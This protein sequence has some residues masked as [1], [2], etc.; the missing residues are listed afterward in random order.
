[1]ISRY[2]IDAIFILF[3][4]KTAL[5][6]SISTDTDDGWRIFFDNMRKISRKTVDVDFGND[7]GVIDLFLFI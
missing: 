6:S 7:T 4:D 1:M 3:I 2:Y 5:D